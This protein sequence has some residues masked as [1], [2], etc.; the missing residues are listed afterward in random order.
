MARILIIHGAYNNPRG[1][2]FPW[3]K[4][5]LEKEGQAVDVPEFPT[6]VNQSLENWE[7]VM[8][9]QKLP[10]DA[11]LVGHSLGAAFI[12]SYLE[13]R[14]ARAA[15]LVGGFHKPLGISL[16]KLNATFVEKEFNWSMMKENCSVRVCIS[17]DNDPYIP[18]EVS[19]ELARKFDAESIVVRGGGHLN[20]DSGFSTFPLIKEKIIEMAR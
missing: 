7:K 3:L 5:E 13:K 4:Q 15:F 8:G 11:I 16:D 12:L 9:R 2:W 20:K 19:K 10:D 17:S 18:L 6:P 1:N 14:K